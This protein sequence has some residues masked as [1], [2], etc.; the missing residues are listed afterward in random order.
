MATKQQLEDVEQAVRE[1]LET[2]SFE[3]EL[4][5]LL[6]DLETEA[7]L[8]WQHRDRPQYAKFFVAGADDAYEQLR[9]LIT[10]K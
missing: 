3:V 9:Q 5:R 10:V 7:V 2:R 4:H 8:A 6:V 1:A